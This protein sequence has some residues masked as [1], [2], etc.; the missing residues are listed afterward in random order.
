MTVLL[1]IYMLHFSKS[2]PHSAMSNTSNTEVMSNFENKVKDES[3]ERHDENNVVIEPQFGNYSEGNVKFDMHFVHIPKC[4][5]TSMTA[6]LRQVAC[7]IDPQR[8]NDCCTNPGFCD[9]HAK[10][11]CASIKGCINHFP[12]R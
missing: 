10:R 6:V 4:G 8:N 3:Y 11:R 1:Y 7:V 5:G 12:Q 9:W 2:P